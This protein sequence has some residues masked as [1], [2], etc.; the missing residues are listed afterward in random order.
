[1]AWNVELT[2]TAEKQLKKLDRKW[3]GII[4]DYLEDE[5]ADLSDP[6]SR[7]KG[8][9]GDRKGIWRYRVGDYRIL[10]RQPVQRSRTDEPSAFRVGAFGTGRNSVQRIVRALRIRRRVGGALVC[11]CDSYLHSE[12]SA[13]LG[14][15]APYSSST[16]RASPTTELT[17]SAHF[18]F[19]WTRSVGCSGRIPLETRSHRMLRSCLDPCFREA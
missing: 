10:C 3:Q 7:G 15:L 12:V 17:R 2:A 19:S 5:I 16:I 4:L 1:L 8:L 6:R 13:N 11:R 9:V 18:A 14:R